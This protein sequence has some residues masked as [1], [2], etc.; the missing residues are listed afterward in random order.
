MFLP[1][2]L[3]GNCA[4]AFVSLRHLSSPQSIHRASPA[5][6]DSSEKSTIPQLPPIGSSSFG[7]IPSMATAQPVSNVASEKFELQYTC[8]IC[9]TRNVHRVSRIGKHSTMAVSAKRYYTCMKL[10]L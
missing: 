8:K 5:D 6:D 10:P 2:L 7:V 4:G 3:I 1:Y 9:E